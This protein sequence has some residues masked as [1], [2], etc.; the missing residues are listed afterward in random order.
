MSSVIRFLEQA[1]QGQYNKAQMQSAIS[2]LD[3]NP[4]QRRALEQ[5]DIEMLAASMGGRGEM[6]CWVFT[7]E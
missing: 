4:A 3:V 6:C 2:A 5:G 1:G 7:G